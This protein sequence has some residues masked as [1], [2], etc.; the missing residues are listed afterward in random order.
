MVNT[1]LLNKT[2]GTTLVL[3]HCGQFKVLPSSNLMGFPNRLGSSGPNAPNQ[4]VLTPPKA[5]NATV[6]RKPYPV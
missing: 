2:L 6:K 3:V 1:F 5:V 4:N